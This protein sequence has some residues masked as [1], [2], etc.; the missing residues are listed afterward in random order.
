MVPY[1]QRQKI[2][3]AE[4]QPKLVTRIPLHCTWSKG[5]GFG[6]AAPQHLLPFLPARRDK[7]SH[8]EGQNHAIFVARP[9]I[10]QEDESL[11]RDWISRHHCA[12]TAPVLVHVTDPPRY[13]A[14]C[15]SGD[16]EF[17]DITQHEAVCFGR[18]TPGSQAGEILR[19][20]PAGSEVQGSR[21]SYWHY[22][23]NTAE[24]FVNIPRCAASAPYPGFRN[25][26]NFPGGQ[27]FIA[28][29]SGNFGGLRLVGQL[30]KPSLW[31]SFDFGSRSAVDF[32]RLAK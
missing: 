13:C 1:C 21:H 4:C 8:T 2:D 7:H 28:K 17:T 19:L 15:S 30:Q 23:L 22:L 20:R 24:R 16:S 14:G 18:P 5:P 31:F 26:P 12:L 25:Q 29:P 27:R 9:D 3:G 11:R 10:E 32:R 6:D